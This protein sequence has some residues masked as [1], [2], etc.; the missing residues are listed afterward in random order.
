MAR[1]RNIKPGFFKN[2]ELAEIEPLG[3]ILFA[4]LWC[5]ADRE[6]RLED[7]PKRIKADILPYDD[8]D[9]D[10]LLWALHDRNFIVRYRV[11]DNRYIQVVNFVKHQDPHINERPS[12]I[13]AL[14]AIGATREEYG[15]STVQVPEDSGSNPPDS[16]FSDSLIPDPSSLIPKEETTSDDIPADATETER[17]V[18]HELSEVEGYPFSYERDLEHI[19]K[20]AVDFPEIDLLLTVKDW[21]TYKLDHPL[22]KKSNP[23]SQLRTWFKNEREFRKKRTAGKTQRKSF[24]PYK[25]AEEIAND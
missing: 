16:L 12:V 11:G 19:R 10:A 22:E 2:D 5:I 15:T 1:S 3:R 8:C 7:R 4:G 23:R 13:P 20:L 17:K 25:L 18:L 14:D 24:D 6:G 9:L 21:A